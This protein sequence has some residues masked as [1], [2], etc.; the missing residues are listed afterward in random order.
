MTSGKAVATARVNGCA[1]VETPA[2][3]AAASGSHAAAGEQ[4]KQ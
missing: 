4:R 2:V 1:K 3:A